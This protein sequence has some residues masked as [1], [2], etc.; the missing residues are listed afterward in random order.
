ME[1][2]EFGEFLVEFVH[3][4]TREGVGV[5]LGRP[6]LEERFSVLSDLE[7][8]GGVHGVKVKGLKGLRV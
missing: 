4:R 5:E 3:A 7:V 8:G 6:I 1:F 2:L